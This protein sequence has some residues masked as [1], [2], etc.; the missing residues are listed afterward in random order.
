MFKVG[1]V[2]KLKESMWKGL[3][4]AKY[5]L[6]LERGYTVTVYIDSKYPSVGL[7][8]FGSL[9]DAA[10]F[11]LVIED[12]PKRFTQGDKV[13]STRDTPSIPEGFV[14]YVVEKPSNSCND[15]EYA[16]KGCIGLGNIEYFNEE[17]L[18]LLSAN[19]D[20]KLR[21]MVLNTIAD[22]E[23][24]TGGSVNYYK[25]LVSN[26]TTLDQP[27]YAE[28]NDI[29]ESLGLTFAEGNLLKAVWRIAADRNGKKKKGNNSVYDAEKLVFFAER[30]LSREKAK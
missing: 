25:V 12:K 26:P 7:N 9:F 24:H 10:H 6:A 16:V 19:L 15:Y 4:P 3:T 2:V 8:E 29:I 20:D 14:G 21:S 27:Y 23:E 22:K 13:I 1:D 11:E 30:I 17:E 18:E 28:A 5:G